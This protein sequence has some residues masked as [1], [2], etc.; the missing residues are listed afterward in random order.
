MTLKKKKD[1]A[2]D[3]SIATPKISAGVRIN[4]LKPIAG[5]DQDNYIQKVDRSE[6]VIP[7]LESTMTGPPK[8]KI[9]RTLENKEVVIKYIE[10]GMTQVDAAALAGIGLSTFHTWYRVDPEFKDRCIQANQKFKMKHLSNIGQHAAVD[11]KASA[12]LLARKFPAEF[13]EKKEI[14]IQQ[15]GPTAQNLVIAFLGQI[16]AAKGYIAPEAISIDI[17][18][19]LANKEVIEAAVSDEDAEPEDELDDE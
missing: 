7:D 8:G 17:S 1:P 5:F 13:G 11:W 3:T 10:Q 6:I 14:T 12:W 19:A 9:Q 15:E 4:S 2:K 18:K 16:N